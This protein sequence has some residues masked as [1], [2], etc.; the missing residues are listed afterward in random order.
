MKVECVSCG[1]ELNL[2]HWV[3]DDYEGSVKCFFCSRIMEVKTAKGIVYSISPPAIT[4][5]KRNPA[6]AETGD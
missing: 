4:E 6:L 2:D 1:H 3:F 5:S